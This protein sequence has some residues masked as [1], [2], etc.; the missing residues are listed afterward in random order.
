MRVLHLIV[1]RKWFNLIKSGKKTTEYRRICPHWES[2][3]IDKNGRIIQFDEVHFTN[4]YHG[5]SPKVKCVW[6]GMK[7]NKRTG[8][9][10]IKLGGLIP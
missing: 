2:R 10:E 9:F 1:K 8:C 3:L 5:N 6:K 4:G 7:I